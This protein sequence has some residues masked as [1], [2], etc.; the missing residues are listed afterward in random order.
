MDRAPRL[1]AFIERF[2]LLLGEARNEAAI[3]RDGAPL[4]AELVRNDDWLPARFG[5]SPQQGYAQYLLHCDP[6]Q[7]FCVVSFAWAPGA[8]TPIHDH[9]VWGMVAVKRGA[10]N[11]YE[12]DLPRPGAAL[13]PKGQHLL[14]VGSIDRVS[15]TIGDVHVVENALADRPS[16]SIHV[17]GGDIGRIARHV[18]DPQTGEAKPFVS[19]YSNA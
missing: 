9:T 2:G 16:L 10:E 8:R 13:R 11:C 6:R 5:R 4:L 15:P 17:Y 18:F 19:G 12:Y 1:D 7:R 3:F 14:P